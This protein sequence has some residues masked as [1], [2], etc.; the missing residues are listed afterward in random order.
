MQNCK[1]INKD[2]IEW[3]KKYY[4]IKGDSRNSLLR[5]K[6]VLFQTLALDASIIKA[7]SFIKPE[8]KNNRVLDVGCGGGGS[9][10]NFIRMGFPPENLTGIDI[11]E[12]RISEGKR[13]FPNATFVQ[14]DAAR[15]RFENET[16]DIVTESTMF[17]QIIDD[18]L[19]QSIAN[20]MIR[21]TK[22]NGYII[23]VDW[24]YSKPWDKS[25]KG[26]NMRRIKELF[27][28]NSRTK[29]KGIFKGA[30]I[31]PIG[32]LISKRFPCLYFLLQSLFPFLAGQITCVLQKK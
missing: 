2:T 24:R 23:L 30:I 22:A 5:N 9:I 32:R 12:E 8:P 4:E 29:I 7:I 6:E 26:L 31:P 28:V 21:V 3:Y 11:Q 17:V 16:F 25:Y 15:M 13:L 1:N 20:E 18:V 14:G 19:S 10:L 27:C